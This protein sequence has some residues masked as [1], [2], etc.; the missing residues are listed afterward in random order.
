MRDFLEK[1]KSKYIKCGEICLDFFHKYYLII[2]PLIVTV[3]ALVIRYTIIMFPTGDLAGIVFSW[4]RGIQEVGFSK[5]YTVKSDYTPLFMFVIAIITLLPTGKLVTVDGYTFYVNWMYYVKSIYFITDILFAIGIYLL[6]KHLT[7][8]KKLGVLGYVIALVL[9]VQIA[10]SAIWGNCDSVYFCFFV[11]AIYF[12]L[13]KRD[14]LAWVFVGL[15]LALKL[16]AV[17]IFPFMLYL[18][19]RRKIRL[20]PIVV[21]VLVFFACLIPAYICGASFTQPFNAFKA[22]LGQYPQLTL[23]CAN[24]WKFFFEDVSGDKLNIINN[25]AVWIGLAL[26]GVFFAIIYYKNVELSDKNIV[27]VGIF[28]IAIVPFF[29]PHMHERYFY[30]LDVLVLVYALYQ[31]RRWFL[32][33]LM[34]ISSGIAYYH[35]L[36]GHY[37]I[38]SWGENSVTI[39]AVINIIVL[40]VLFHD[41]MKLSSIGPLFNKKEEKQIENN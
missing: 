41:I 22:Q 40:A 10:N 24:F 18:V 23:G 16:Q 3:L 13:K 25:S 21:A 37:I 19:L 14:I 35:Y 6:V 36:T 26:I 39:A 28:L 38:E 34:Q 12:I 11:Y 8:S 15:A 20:W 1:V 30:P 9:P 27:L 31:S 29:L 2:I 4:M 7:G 17:F 5:F 32:V 33:V